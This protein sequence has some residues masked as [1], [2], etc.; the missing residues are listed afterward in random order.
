MRTHWGVMRSPA[1]I[2][3]CRRRELGDL[4]LAEV[5]ARV[6]AAVTALL[7]TYAP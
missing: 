7:A 3:M 4:T 1:T 6:E 5:D 2:G